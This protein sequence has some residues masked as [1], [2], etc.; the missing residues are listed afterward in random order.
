MLDDALDRIA[1]QGAESDAGAVAATDPVPQHVRGT[2]TDHTETA[3]H[4]PERRKHHITTVSFNFIGR[5][6]RN[7]YFI[8]GPG[9][10]EL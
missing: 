2:G 8:V 10:R 4:Q 1:D 9:I 5:V 3:Q 6:W 7:E